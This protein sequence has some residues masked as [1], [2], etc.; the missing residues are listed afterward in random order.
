M[1]GSFNNATRGRNSALR[2]IIDCESQYIVKLT[3]TS[4]REEE[5]LKD[6]PL[7]EYISYNELNEEEIRR[8]AKTNADFYGVKLSKIEIFTVDAKPLKEL[9][10]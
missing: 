2:K 8:D 9:D 10:L 6:K 1:G 7:H 5:E 4:N 3:S